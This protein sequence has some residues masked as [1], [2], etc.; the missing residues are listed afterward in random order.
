MIRAEPSRTAL[1]EGL[2]HE[3]DAEGGRLLPTR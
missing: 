1:V 3:G 2:A